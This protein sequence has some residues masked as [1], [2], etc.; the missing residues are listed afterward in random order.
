MP[1]REFKLSYSQLIISIIYFIVV[2][3]C[4]ADDNRTEEAR[5]LGKASLWTSIIG[6]RFKYSL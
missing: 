4:A 1:L 2:S 5:K 3:S 6:K